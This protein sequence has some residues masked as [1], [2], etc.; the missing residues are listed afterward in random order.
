MSGLISKGKAPDI[1]NRYRTLFISGNIRRKISVILEHKFF[2]MKRYFSI[3]LLCLAFHTAFGQS[4]KDQVSRACLNYLEGF[5]E[6][7]TIKL[8]ESLK[9]TLHK[10]GLMKDPSTGKYAPDGYM[11]YRQA[12]N[13]A[14][15]VLK[16]KRFPGPDA[17][18]KVEVLD[19][20][21]AIA[22]AKVTAW[23]GVDYILLTKLN[24]KWMI[25]QVLWEGGE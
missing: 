14:K 24:G 1:H 25:E 15:S 19:I 17:P 13:Y 23:W 16:S 9:P 20:S 21:N 5:Y 3:L 4:E 2:K 22:S 12:L 18:K 8:I 10:Y 11:T 7:D 6:G